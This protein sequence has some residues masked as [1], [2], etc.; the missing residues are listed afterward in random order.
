MLV[1]LLTDVDALELLV[2]LAEEIDESPV[3]LSVVPK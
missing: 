3:R 2:D 1:T